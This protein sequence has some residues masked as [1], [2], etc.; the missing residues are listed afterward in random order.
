MIFEADG[1]THYLEAWRIDDERKR[2]SDFGA[3][4]FLDQD[5]IDRAAKDGVKIDINEYFN[6]LFAS[7]GVNPTGG[8]IW[9]AGWISVKGVLQYYPGLT[10]EILK[11]HGFKTGGAAA[12]GGLISLPLQGKKNSGNRGEATEQGLDVLKFLRTLPRSDPTPHEIAVGWNK[13]SSEARAPTKLLGLRPALGYSA[14]IGPVP[15]FR[16]YPL[17]PFDTPSP[18]PGRIPR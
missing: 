16:P 4:S 9:S 17:P 6:D 11:E 12:A 18:G 1:V 8:Q 13:G 7:V 2:P 10:P 15:T 14:I 3:K 5:T